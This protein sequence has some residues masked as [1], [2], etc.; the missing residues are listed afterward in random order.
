MNRRDFLSVSASALTLFAAPTLRADILK[1]RDATMHGQR[2]RSVWL[3]ANRL[4]GVTLA[5]SGDQIQVVFFIDLNCPAVRNSG[6]G[7]IRRNDASGR[8]AG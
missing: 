4:T 6:A 1:G 2:D 8:R 7:S 5:K 3:A